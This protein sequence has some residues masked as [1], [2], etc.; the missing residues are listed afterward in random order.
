M[1]KKLHA[2]L[3]QSQLVSAAMRAFSIV[4]RLSERKSM[5]L[6]ELSRE[7]GLAKATAYR[8]LLTL[9]ELGY[10]RRV[11]S[12][13]WALTLRMFN[14]GSRSLERLDLLEASRPACEAL[15]EA[16]RETV[17]LG[18]EDEGEVVYILKV[19]ASYSVRMH[20]RVGRRVPLHA[21][22]MGKCLLAF[23]DPPARED[24][25][26]PGRLV[27]M[28]PHTLVER[29][30]LARELELVRAGGFARDREEFEEGIRCLG[31]PIFDHT[32]DVVAAVSV[33]WPA[34]RYADLDEEAAIAEIRQAA[35][36]ISGLLGFEGR[37]RNSL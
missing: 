34:F 16:L 36:Q 22:A 14:V 1:A 3:P 37:S 9:Q 7:L 31:A 30:D 11:G 15:G 13:G 23:L 5:G 28:T 32:G 19:E 29:E 17:H 33:S 35:H 8:F 10:V 20:S 12:E 25:L 27:A 6:D 4:E 2:T 24:L 18:V 21:S 26:G